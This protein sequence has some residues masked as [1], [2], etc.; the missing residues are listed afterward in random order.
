[1]GTL[2]RP[3]HLLFLDEA[4]ADHLVHRR[5]HKRR[6]DYLAVP[7]A[8]AIVRNERLVRPDVGVEGQEELD[9]VERVVLLAQGQKGVRAAT[10]FRRRGTS[11]T[12]AYR[13]MMAWG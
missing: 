10:L 11:A 13:V 9:Q 2:L 4:L 6:R 12:D 3:A 1:M 7:I 8:V 5:L